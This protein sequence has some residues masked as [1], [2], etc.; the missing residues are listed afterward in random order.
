MKKYLKK[1]MIFLL[2]IALF[3][4]SAQASLE[5]EIIR[6]GLFYGSTALPTANLEN[7]SGSGYRFGYFDESGSFVTLG[8]TGETQISM[9]KTQNIYLKSGTYSTAAP[10]SPEGLVGCYHIQLPGNYADFAA[11]KAAAAGYPGGF[12]AWSSGQY[13]VRVGAYGTRDEAQAAQRDRSL[14][15]SIVGTSSYGITV[16]KTKTTTVLFQFDSGGA[17]VFSVRPGQDD[18]VKTVTWFKGYRYYG[19]FLYERVDGGDLTVSNRVGLDDYAKGVVPH[20]MSPSWPLEAL[21]AQAVTAKNYALTISA[22]KHSKYHFDVCNGTCCQVYRGRNNASDASDK[23][24]DET[25]GV[26]VWYDGALAETYYYAS[27]GGAAEDVKNVWGTSCPYLVGVK[28]PYEGTIS[29]SIS[30]YN[31]TV[32]YTP[33]QLTS[34]LQDRGYALGNVVSLKVTQLTA[35]G[36]VFSIEIK[37]ENGKT[38]LFTRE[39]A[40]TI[41]GLNSMHFQISGGSGSGP[42]GYYVDDGGQTI[43]TLSGAWI[44]GGDGKTAQVSGSSGYYAVTGAGTELLSSE[45]SSA[46]APGVF[47]ITGSGNGHHVGMSQWGANAMAKQGLTYQDILRFYYAGIDIY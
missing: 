8:S 6:V 12:P 4:V 13:A 9:L 37:D 19:D 17:K 20:E 32:T 39:R 21:K 1:S 30:N 34:R 46:G 25:H 10:G 23:A 40:R 5:D 35:L 2:L 24:V 43:P 29:G 22:S 14:S 45:G 31:W 18:G 28:D 15:G 11:A 38:Q 27:N 41:L 7:S 33:A 26:Y 36:N 44:I 3:A 16:T 47:T 42:S